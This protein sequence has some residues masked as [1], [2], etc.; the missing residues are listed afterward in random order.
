MVK[1]KAAISAS[2]L[3]IN[4]IDNN[5]VLHLKIVHLWLRKNFADITL[6]ARERTI[7]GLSRTRSSVLMLNNRINSIEL[8][9]VHRETL[10]FVVVLPALQNQASN[11]TSFLATSYIDVHE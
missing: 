3:A 11:D 6:G 2:L 5:S 9:Y 8:D 1:V 10:V 4:S 7:Q